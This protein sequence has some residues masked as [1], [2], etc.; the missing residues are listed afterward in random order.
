MLVHRG[1][2]HPMDFKH[3][4]LHSSRLLGL[5]RSFGI[6]EWFKDDFVHREGWLD[7]RTSLRHLLLSVDLGDFVSQVDRT[8]MCAHKFVLTCR[9]LEPAS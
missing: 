2:T 9:L 1:V 4:M 6:V 5:G 7:R 8:D 3:V